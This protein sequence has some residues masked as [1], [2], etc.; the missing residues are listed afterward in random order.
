MRLGR[1]LLADDDEMV[2]EGLSERLRRAGY[3]CACA[4]GATSALELLRTDSFDALI[5]DIHMPGNA[6]LE[7]IQAVPQVATGLPIILLTGRPSVETAARSVRLRAYA[8]LVKP[9]VHDELVTLLNLAIAE[10]RQRRTVRESRERLQGLE[11]ELESIESAFEM[12]RAAADEV[13]IASFL[14]LTLRNI[15]ASIVDL[16]RSARLVGQNEE[17]GLLFQR[18]E[19]ITALRNTVDVL[20]K[21][22]Q[23]FKSKDLANLRFQLERLLNQ[24][25]APSSPKSCAAES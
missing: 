8:Y 15:A 6:E 13:P 16:E 5:A 10:Y 20:E 23:N 24:S 9:P 12:G 21:T 2:R 17:A 22:K 3:D 14:R 19:L 7:L 25:E 18:A 4:D 1:I 11:R